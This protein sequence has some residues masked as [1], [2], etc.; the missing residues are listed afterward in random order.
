LAITLLFSHSV[1]A[2]YIWLEAPTSTK[3]GKEVNIKIYY[4]EYNE[5]VREIKGGRLEELNGIVFW[6]IAPNGTKTKLP[7]NIEEKNFQVKFTPFTKGIY[8]F[9]ATNKVKEVADW[10]KFNIGIV[11]PQYYA[12]S[13]LQVG[14]SNLFADKIMYPELAITPILSKDKK[15]KFQLLYYN[16]PFAN[17]KLSLHGP[18]LWSK[19]FKTDANGFFTADAIG[20]GLYLIECIYKESKSGNFNNIKFEGIRHRA[21]YSYLI[22]DKS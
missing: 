17:T 10:S 7:V 16:K 4:G 22:T 12:S 13:Q 2:H 11:K 18:N 1:F 3:I 19:E 5:G 14:K 20:K 15:Q 9:L 8:T 6:V 21:T